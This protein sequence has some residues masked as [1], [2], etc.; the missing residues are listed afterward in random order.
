MIDA[1]TKALGAQVAPLNMTAQPLPA[2][3]G[4][5][6][7]AFNAQPYTQALGQINQAVTAD[8]SNIATNQGQVAQQL[9]NSYSN[10]YASATVAAAPQATPQAAGLQGGAADPAAAQQVNAAGAGD[11]AAFQNLMQ[12]LGAANQASQQSRMAQVGMDANYANQQLGAQ[13][14]GLR[15]GVNTAQAQAQNQWTQAQRER[16]Y[17]NSLMQ[18]Q[19][20]REDTQRRQDLAN[21][22]RQ[23]N[24]TQANQ[25][26]T[27]RLQP[28]LDLISQSAGVPGLNFDPLLKIL[29]GIR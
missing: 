11:Q 22:N 10:P 5:A 24:W 3:R 19:W 13:A 4:Q 17:Q 6:L 21:Q 25:T 9:Q 20:L 1:M 7:G 16:S 18:Q 27:S 2:F 15:G 12:V 26:M 14:L 28:I 8:R 23:S 29:G